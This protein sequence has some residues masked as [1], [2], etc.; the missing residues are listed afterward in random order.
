M[1]TRGAR[2]AGA[3]PRF[4]KAHPLSEIIK[5]RLTGSAGAKRT[6]RELHCFAGNR[7]NGVEI[8]STSPLRLFH[9][10][11]NVAFIV[12]ASFLPPIG[13]VGSVARSIAPVSIKAM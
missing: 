2:Q 5:I 3:L 12:V 8:I 6:S 4:R 9:R 7:I 11:R 13:G 10:R 1:L